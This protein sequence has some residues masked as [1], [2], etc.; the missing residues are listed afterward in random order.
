MSAYLITYDLVGTD[1]T[2]ENYD[3]IIAA[4]KSYKNWA[5][6][7]DSVWAINTPSTAEQIYEKVRKH[8]HAKDRLMVLR[9]GGDWVSENHKCTGKWL[10]DNL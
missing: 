3:K 8:M 9:S 2:S 10:K 6:V 4:I 7:Q 5:H 1:S